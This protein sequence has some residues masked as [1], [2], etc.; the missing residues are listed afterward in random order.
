MALPIPEDCDP[1]LRR[2]YE[3]WVSIH[4]RG[5]GLPGRQHVDPTDVPDLLPWIW[6]VDVQRQPLRFKY[7]L[8]GTEYAKAMEADFTGRWIDEVH[9][10]FLGSLAYPQYVAAAE[11]GEIGYIKGPPTFHTPKSYIS[12]ERLLLPLAR[13]G[14]TV[15]MLL[16][17]TIYQRRGASRS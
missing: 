16:A 2:F 4:P 14:C 7:R 15:D 11:R 17:I 1:R 13:D 5:G 10:K 12:R 6:M 8:L 3:Y 9:P